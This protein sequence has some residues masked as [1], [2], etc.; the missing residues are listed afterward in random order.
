MA[1]AEVSGRPAR[2]VRINGESQI[3]TDDYI[4]R[5]LNLEI[6]DNIVVGLTTDAGEVA[7][8]SQGL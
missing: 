7:G 3:T 4:A 1:K 5:R 6:V 2:I 8:D